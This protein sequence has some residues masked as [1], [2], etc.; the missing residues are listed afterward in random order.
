MNWTVSRGW[1]VDH[2]KPRYLKTYL[3]FFIPIT[4]LLLMLSVAYYLKESNHNTAL[5]E[6]KEAF[7][8]EK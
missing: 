1:P 4:T 3:T 5:L 8:I 7:T 2:I 6:K